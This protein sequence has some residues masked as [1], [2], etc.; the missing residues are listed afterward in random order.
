MVISS[1]TNAARRLCGGTTGAKS[2]VKLND[3]N[4]VVKD[5]DVY[6]KSH[7]PKD[8]A[9]SVGLD[10]P[11]MQRLK[12]NSVRQSHAQSVSYSYVYPQLSPSAHLMPS[13][14]ALQ[15]TSC[16]VAC[17]P[18][19]LRAAAAGSVAPA[20]HALSHSPLLPC[21]FSNLAQ[22]LEGPQGAELDLMAPLFTIFI[23]LAALGS[24]VLLSCSGAESSRL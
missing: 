12:Q 11:E 17:A 10:M 9:T 8:V 6:H 16:S 15:L 18:R 7:V 14:Y 21:A 3:H 5:G 23:M 24:V 1:N 4:A 13:P 20:C 19:P 2:G 22:V